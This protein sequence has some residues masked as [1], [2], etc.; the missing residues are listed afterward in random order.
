MKKVK[1]K[2]KRNK[3]NIINDNK[4]E[5]SII[6]NKIYGTILK[7][8]TRSLQMHE[9]EV[10]AELISR[11]DFNSLDDEIIKFQILCDDLKEKGVDITCLI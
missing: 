3:K 8:D 1:S 4:K 9:H 6:I 10:Y 11:N 7:L 2:N 5:L